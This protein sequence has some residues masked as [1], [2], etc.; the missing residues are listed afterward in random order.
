M[1]QKKIMVTIRSDGDI[2]VRAVLDD[3]TLQLESGVRR[4]DVEF[5]NG[6]VEF[7]TIEAGVPL[8]APVV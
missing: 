5:E 2:N 3:V 7:D 1:A 4:G 8:T 6:T